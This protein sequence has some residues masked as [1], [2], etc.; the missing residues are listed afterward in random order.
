MSEGSMSSFDF[1]RYLGLVLRRKYLALTV[2]FAVLAT[3]TLAGY[4]MPRVYEATSTIF[5]QR[6]TLINPLIQG[7]GVAGN[8]EEG[9]RTLR[10]SMTSRNIITRVIKKLDLDAG[11][12]PQKVEAM[13][14]GIR[15]NVAITVKGGTGGRET[16]DLFTISYRGSNPKRVKDIVN[17]LV[18]EYI[19]ETLGYRRSDAYGAFEFVQSQLTEYKNKLEESD[20]AIREFRERHPDIVPQTEGAVLTRMEAFQTQKIDADI[21]VQE[22]SQRRNNLKRQLSGEKELTVAFV[23]REG[24]PEGRLSYLNNQLVLLSTKFTEKH[25]EILK[26]KAE[27]EELKKQIAH[28]RANPPGAGGSETA[29]LNPIYQQIKEDL[30]K[31]DA[32]IESLRARSSELV[33]QQQMAK[34]VLGGMPKEQ[35]EWTKLQRDR[36][37]Y[38]HIYDDLLNKLETA[39]VSKDL[40]LTDKGTSFKIV[41]AAI[42]PTYPMKPD[43]IKFM[44][45]GIFLG[46]ASGIGAVL[47]LDYLKHAFKD[48]DAI[49]EALKLP[50]LVSIPSVGVEVDSAAAKDFDK[51]VYIASLA[52]LGI[53]LILLAK[54][55]AYKYM[56]I[57]FLGF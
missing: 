27:I 36:N 22:L 55:I 31:T 10:D 45:A 54:E 12:S 3:C 18:E 23:S 16:A 52:F 35:E 4:I 30:A 44:L 49:E 21:K 28:A 2:G 48:E 42:L 40:E 39:R 34:N 20:K 43:R 11:G 38:Q 6:S 1:K 29:T 8:I 33:R 57:S 50:V 51:K 19:A 15:S 25:P 5:I 24:S 46:I 7:V 37:V 13:V 17:T 56:G 26:T 9:L 41:D 53:I 32:E 47:G 14:E